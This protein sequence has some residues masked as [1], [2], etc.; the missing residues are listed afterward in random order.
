MSNVLWITGLSAAGK[1]TLATLVTERMRSHGHAVVMMDGDL[2]RE[3]MGTTT[4]HTRA[5]RLE[6]AHKYAGL[7]RMVARQNVTVV[8]SAVALFKEIHQW[9]RDNLPGYFE[10]FIKVGLDELR[11]RDPKG[12]YARYDQGL[13]SNVAGLDVP[14]DEP[15]NPDLLLEYSQGMTP[16]LALEKVR[17]GFA[18]AYPDAPK[19]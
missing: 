3:A 5:D 6:L 18:Q 1:T 12:I 7:A 9:N 8:V 15:A 10:I 2:L 4:Q 11:E 16:E 19:F 17:D 14:V 13:I